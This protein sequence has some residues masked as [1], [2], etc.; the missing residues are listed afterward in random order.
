MS[1]HAI[2]SPSSADRW[3]LCPGSVPYN[4][5]REGTSSA[6]AA[7]G[8]AAH[9]LAELTLLND[10]DPVVYEGESFDGVEFTSDMVREVRKYTEFV[11]DLV[12]S[13]GGELHVEVGLP[14]GHLT[15]E[16]DA[17]GTSDVVII[18]PRELIVV[19]LKYGRGVEVFADDNRQLKIYGLGA[20]RRFGFTEAQGVKEVRLVIAQPRLN[21]WSEWTISVE[22]L[23]RF[24]IEVGEAAGASTDVRVPGEKQC[25][26]CA[27]KADCPELREYTLTA[28]G[29]ISFDDVSKVTVASVS[30]LS[31][32]E[33][34]LIASK[35]DLIDSWA[36]AV[37][38][39]LG[40]ALE[41]QDVPGWKLV[42]GKQ[43]NRAW[44][45]EAEAEAKLKSMKLKQD[46]M[47]AR[48]LISPTQAEKVLADSP[49]RWAKIAP[50]IARRDGKPSI[51][52]EGDKRPA[53]P[54]QGVLA[55]TDESTPGGGDAD[56]GISGAERAAVVLIAPEAKGA[57]IRDL[58]RAV[59]TAS[60]A[61][62]DAGQAAQAAM[63]AVELADSILARHRH[64]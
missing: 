61:A 23:E 38:G 51:A 9:K 13:T 16:D 5:D 41:T 29:A 25:R 35:L 62:W 33:L 24:A 2:R 6:A 58:E 20:L 15:G 44:A 48:S 3:M 10:T 19:D 45:D 22:D 36:K 28:L 4:T 64:G 21:N 47:Y 50:L 52:K 31:A 17:A 7:E 55:F 46:E 49:K 53:L 26:W 37:W 63:D 60:N 56:A 59:E 32:E 57:E 27:G 54:K 30:T 34:G 40:L 14:I 1:T 39:K 11:R 8:T 43:G 18:T 42:A 12:A